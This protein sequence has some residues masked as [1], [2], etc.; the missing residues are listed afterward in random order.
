MLWRLWIVVTVPWTL[1]AGYVGLSGLDDW[2]AVAS[3]AWVPFVI[4]ALGRGIVWAI[5]G[6]RE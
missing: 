4:L 1:L 6:L 2:G 5:D 3:V